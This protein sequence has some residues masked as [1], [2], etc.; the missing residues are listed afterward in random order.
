MDGLYWCCL[1]SHNVPPMCGC[2]IS[3]NWSICG[4]FPGVLRTIVL[5]GGVQLVSIAMEIWWKVK[6]AVNKCMPGG[7]DR[8]EKAFSTTQ[9]A[10]KPVLYPSCHRVATFDMVS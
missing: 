7:V 5:D 10:D 9:V 3:W 8:S 2:N 4:P 6:I 1:D